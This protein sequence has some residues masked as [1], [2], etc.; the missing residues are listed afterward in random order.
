V[1]GVPL[2]SAEEDGLGGAQGWT[3]Q[4][5]AGSRHGIHSVRGTQKSPARGG[6]N[7]SRRT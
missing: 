7:Q 4:V 1:A 5:E 6:A 3:W 2:A